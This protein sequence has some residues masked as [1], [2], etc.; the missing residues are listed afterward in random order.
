[1]SSLICDATT[2]LERMYNVRDAHTFNIKTHNWEHWLP[3]EHENEI[4]AL[5]YTHTSKMP[6]Y[7]YLICANGV[8]YVCGVHNSSEIFFLLFEEML[9]RNNDARSLNANGRSKKYK[10]FFCGLNTI[11][12]TLQQL[13]ICKNEQFFVVVSLWIKANW[14]VEWT[15][16]YEYPKRNAAMFVGS[17]GLVWRRWWTWKSRMRSAAKVSNIKNKM[18]L[19]LIVRSTFNTSSIY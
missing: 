7:N 5:T 10:R 12:K 16:L 13:Q 1:M 17:F 11:D 15:Y 2:T 6:A 18:N 19:L 3:G 4:C 14:T 9:Q 8:L